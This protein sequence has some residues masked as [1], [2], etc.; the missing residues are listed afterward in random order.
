[1]VEQCISITERYGIYDLKEEMK[2]LL[3]RLNSYRTSL[4]RSW[5]AR[6]MALLIR[7]YAPRGRACDAFKIWSVMRCV[8]SFLS[9]LRVP[10]K[11]MI[12]EEERMLDALDAIA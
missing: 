6:K 1:M 8:V 11:V 2:V 5:H 10:D 4:E 9:P 12:T 3:E 7:N